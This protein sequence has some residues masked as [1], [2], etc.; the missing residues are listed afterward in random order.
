MLKFEF[1][2]EVVITFIKSIKKASSGRLC[3]LYTKASY[4]ICYKSTSIE[5]GDQ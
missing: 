1:K 5:F 4:M 2:A 3:P